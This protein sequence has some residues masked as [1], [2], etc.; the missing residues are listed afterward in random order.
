MVYK[1]NANEHF[2][3]FAAFLLQSL[4]VMSSY[5]FLLSRHL[6]TSEGSNDLIPATTR[7]FLSK[8]VQVYTSVWSFADDED[9]RC[10]ISIVEFLDRINSRS[11]SLNSLELM[12]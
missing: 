7:L 6:H 8:I 5:C 1:R 4:L 12:S 9:E 3:R 2:E 11:T 10:F